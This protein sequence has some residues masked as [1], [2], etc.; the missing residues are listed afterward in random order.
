ML[1]VI[2]TFKTIINLIIML[3]IIITTSP[4]NTMITILA[5]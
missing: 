4:S 1:H 3:A 2:L 5:F